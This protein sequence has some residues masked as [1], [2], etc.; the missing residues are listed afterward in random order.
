MEMVPFDRMELHRYGQKHVFAH[1]LRTLV[2]AHPVGRSR[3]VDVVWTC[4]AP[5][6]VGPEG[7]TVR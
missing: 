7:T 1:T 3:R 5:V 6:L 2:R 4:G